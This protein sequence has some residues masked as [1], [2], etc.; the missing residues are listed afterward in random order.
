MKLDEK[1]RLAG[2]IYHK[3]GTVLHIHEVRKGEVYLQ[4]FPPGVKKQGMF[5]NLFRVP[6]E[7]F[8]KEVEG[9]EMTMDKEV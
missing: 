3:N 7:H 2:R 9:A 1:G 5:S 8:K 4:I 6:L